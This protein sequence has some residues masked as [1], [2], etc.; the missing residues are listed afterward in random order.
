MVCLAPSAHACISVA[1][2]HA[3]PDSTVKN[4]YVGYLQNTPDGKQTYAIAWGNPLCHPDNYAYVAQRW[5]HK[6]ESEGKRPLWSCCSQDFMDV[7]TKSFPHVIGGE[8]ITPATLSTNAKLD[9]S[10]LTCIHEDVVDPRSFT[11]DQVEK[12]V[13]TKLRKA[14]RKGL[15]IV[16]A[17]GRFPDPRLDGSNALSR[18]HVEEGILVWKE[19]KA[20]KGNQ[21]HASDTE[22]WRDLTHRKYFYAVAPKTPPAD[23]DDEGP[24]HG[25][26]AAASAANVSSGKKSAATS[27]SNLSVPNVLL[28]FHDDEKVVGM[29]VLAPIAQGKYVVKWLLEFDQ[30]VKGTSEC[31]IVHVI[32]RLRDAGSPDW[33]TPQKKSAEDDKPLSNREKARRAR[34]ARM[35]AAAAKAQQEEEAAKANDTTDAAEPGKETPPPAADSDVAPGKVV[36]VNAPVETIAEVK[37]D[38]ASPPEKS[39]I[40]EAEAKTENEAD[41][42]TPVS[43]TVIAEQDSKPMRV[44][45]TATSV[46]ASSAALFPLEG[47]GSTPAEWNESKRPVCTSLSFGISGGE[48]KPVRNMHVGLR[49]TTI[50]AAYNALSKTFHLG[51]KGSFR[52]K[53]GAS[54]EVTAYICFPQGSMGYKMIDAIVGALKEDQSSETDVEKIIGNPAAS[55]SDGPGATTPASESPKNAATPL[56]T[57]TNAPTPSAAADATA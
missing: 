23:D 24:Q 19:S 33:P 13:R 27:Q 40:N 49:F 31:L 26:P 34:K 45:S 4:A 3:F 20:A 2:T 56:S 30:E 15:R 42:K 1:L 46:D 41:K 16:E 7:L 51:S 22:P 47:L 57:A 28:D 5:V 37:A 14:H 50:S 29:C 12:F 39:T 25:K 8:A 17:H 36:A 44:Q 9:W 54:H 10:A 53:F 52:T 38:D 35:A 6:I 11:V 18:D 55:G 32:E 21:I 48:L 43:A